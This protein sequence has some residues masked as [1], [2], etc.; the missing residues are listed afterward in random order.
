MISAKKAKKMM[1][2]THYIVM[3]RVRLIIEKKK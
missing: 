1:N 2:T 3:W